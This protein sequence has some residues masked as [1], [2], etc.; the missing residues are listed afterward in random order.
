MKLALNNDFLN[1][2]SGINI[3]RLGVYKEYKEEILIDFVVNEF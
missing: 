2:Y 3:C 1:L